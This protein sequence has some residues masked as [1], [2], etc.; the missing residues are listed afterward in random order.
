[1]TRDEPHRQPQQQ[2]GRQQQQPIEGTHAHARQ[3]HPCVRLGVLQLPG[4]QRHL[5]QEHYHEQEQKNSLE[6]GLVAGRMP[7]QTWRGL[8]DPPDLVW[9]CTSSERK[10]TRGGG[11]GRRCRRPLFIN[12]PRNIAPRNKRALPAGRT[13]VHARTTAM[14]QC[15]LSSVRCSESLPMS[16]PD[17]TLCFSAPVPTLYL[18][19]AQGGSEGRA[20]GRGERDRQQPRHFT[21]HHARK[22]TFA[23]HRTGLA[24]SPSWWP[25][26]VGRH[27]K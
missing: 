8:I 26:A 27:N 6:L 25:R 1:M 5:E 19:R 16:R 15:L 7:P 2:Q 17:V 24:A 14:F 4:V 21:H 10:Q 12:D 3:R 20:G 13:Y 11:G 23:S 18:W 22:R 9:S